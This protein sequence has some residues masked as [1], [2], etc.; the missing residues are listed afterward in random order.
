MT[1]EG[2]QSA[3]ERTSADLVRACGA[4]LNDRELWKE[5]EKRFH[6]RIFLYLLRSCRVSRGDH[7][8]LQDVLLDLAQD[9]YV[10]LIQNDGRILKSFRGDNDFAVLAFLARVSASVVT[11]HFRHGEAEKRKA[12]VLSIENI[13]PILERTP[14]AS[15]ECGPERTDLQASLR[16][17]VYGCRDRPVSGFRIDRPRRRIRSVAAPEEAEGIMSRWGRDH[18]SGGA[19]DGSDAEPRGHMR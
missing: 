19:H 11:D 15:G 8:D 5:F 12:M 2:G 1:Q 17:R 6:K 18:G 14:A 9:V 4:R 13:R 10:R 7:L 3:A 16:G